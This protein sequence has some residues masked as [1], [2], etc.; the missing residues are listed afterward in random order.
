MPRRARVVVPN[1]PV[2]VIQR[3]HDRDAI[4]FRDDDYWRYLNDLKLASS[5]TG[6]AVHAYVLMTNHVHLVVTPKDEQGLGELMRSV[7]S[8]YVRFINLC[9]KRRGTL[10]EG[11]YR[12]ALIE[13]ERYLMTC[14]RYVELNPVR[15]NMV[16]DPA[17]YPWSSYHH[18]ALGKTNQ[19]I[20]E[21]ELYLRLGQAPEQRQAAYQALFS[22]SIKSEQ[23]AF[24]LR[25]TLRDSVMG[26]E[27]FRK[28][29]EMMLGRKVAVNS[30]GGARGSR[31][32]SP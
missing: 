5:K 22:E 14:Y 4:F 17:G 28:Q 32:P 23:A 30:H 16:R 13:S 18:N 19:L 10:W 24:I 31:P 27:L 2:H 3:G 15:A 7:G 8:R 1:M 25:S 6:C 21:H 12:S 9:Y 29:I 26:N 20:K 11:R